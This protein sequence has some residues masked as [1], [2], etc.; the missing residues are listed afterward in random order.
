[1]TT[2][3]L[4]HQINCAF[5]ALFFNCT[6]QVNSFPFNSTLFFLEECFFFFVSL[7]GLCDDVEMSSF[8]NPLIQRNP[9]FLSNVGTIKMAAALHTDTHTHTRGGYATGEG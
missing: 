4:S 3:E 1:M 8:F 7:P 9:F 6:F 5:F 2:A